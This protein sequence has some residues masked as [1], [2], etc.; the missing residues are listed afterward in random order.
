MRSL[1]PALLLAFG[2]SA[3]TLAQAQSCGSGACGSPIFDPIHSITFTKWFDDQGQTA[4]DEEY[5]SGLDQAGGGSSSCT[6]E[7][8]SVDPASGSANGLL[9][10]SDVLTG[11][12]GGSAGT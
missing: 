9:E 2:A 6:F 1:I 11:E 3:G 12:G 7:V 4:T 8:D 10:S 5:M